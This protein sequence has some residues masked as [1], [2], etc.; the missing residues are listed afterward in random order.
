MP[1]HA[2][3]A[4]CDR[5]VYINFFNG[6]V[7]LPYCILKLSYVSKIQKE[8]QAL[9]SQIIAYRFAQFL[10]RAFFQIL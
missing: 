8:F 10:M 4:F 7:F 6:K 9:I 2:E 3:G 5:W 1:V